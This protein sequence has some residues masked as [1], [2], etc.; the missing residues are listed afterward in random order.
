[1]RKRP[2]LLGE[3]VA[4]SRYT[5]LVRNLPDG[6]RLYSHTSPYIAGTHLILWNDGAWDSY[7]T[8]EDAER[9][10]DIEYTR[11]HGLAGIGT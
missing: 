8:L 1:M 9:E 7:P 4:R 10:A 3:A 11:A 2:T 5:K 6:A